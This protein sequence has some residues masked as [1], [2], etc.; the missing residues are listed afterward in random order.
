MRM[1][2]TSQISHF[3]FC[4]LGLCL[5][6][7]SVCHLNWWK[8]SNRLNFIQFLGK[9]FKF[10]HATLNNRILIP[11][12]CWN[13]CSSFF[14]QTFQ[15]IQFGW[16]I[17]E[18]FIWKTFIKLV[19]LLWNWFRNLGFWRIHSKWIF[20]IAET[21]DNILIAAFESFSSS[22]EFQQKFVLCLAS[23]WRQANSSNTIISKC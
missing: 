12:F 9:L 19:Y 6:C 21:I 18:D 11:T 22:S 20:C 5:Q 4:Q 16:G 8:K 3:A 7:R 14:K 23:I 17:S 15:R 13:V 1:N 2:C 10:I